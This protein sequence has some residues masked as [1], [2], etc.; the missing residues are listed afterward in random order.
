MWNID[1]V[2]Y[3]YVHRNIFLERISFV[4]YLINIWLYVIIKSGSLVQVKWSI[5]DLAGVTLRACIMT[6][7]IENIY[8]LWR[9]D[10]TLR[11]MLVL[12]EGYRRVPI[13]VSNEIDL[14]R[15]R[16]ISIALRYIWLIRMPKINYHQLLST[17]LKKK[18]FVVYTTRF[19]TEILEYS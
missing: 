17:T 6:G 7:T 1:K 2:Y 15:R 8:E 11:A 19:V 5:I 4:I 10:L 12:K 9:L 3:R 18:R 16:W 13:G 14:L